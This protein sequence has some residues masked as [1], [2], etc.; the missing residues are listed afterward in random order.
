MDSIRR[1]DREGVVL[2]VVITAARRR[3][4]K[5]VIQGE[6]GPEQEPQKSTQN[7]RGSG[8]EKNTET[9]GKDRTSKPEGVSDG[10]GESRHTLINPPS[11]AARRNAGC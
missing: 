3:E 11:G 6:V 1:A 4:K 10:R 5:N 8:E 9:E 7:T 2:E